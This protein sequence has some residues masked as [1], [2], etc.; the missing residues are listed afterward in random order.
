MRY[1]INKQ[2]YHTFETFEV[3]KLPARSYFIPFSDKIKADA[4]TILNKRYRS[5]KVRCLNGNWDFCFFSRPAE[6]PDVLDTDAIAFDTIDVPSC[7]QFRGYDKPFYVNKR[8]QF[9][10]NPPVIPK[11]EPVGKTFYVESG[12]FGSK[13]AWATPVEEYNFVGVYRRKFSVDDTKKNRVITFLG[14]A[15]CLDLYV[16]GQFVGYSEGSHNTAEF[17]LT[18]YLHAGENEL[19]AVVHRWCTGTYLECQDMLRNNGIFRDV[20]LYEMDSAD[21]WDVDFRTEWAEQGYSAFAVAELNADAEVKVTLSGHGLHYEQVVQTANKIARVCFKNLDVQQWNAETPVLYDLYF[22]LENTCVKMRV[23][24]RDVKICG[25]VF[26]LNGSRVKLKGVNHHDTH[27]RNGYTMT[28]EEIRYDVQLCKDYNMDTI[29]TSHYPPD[30]MLLEWCDELGV[31]VVDEGD[32]ETHGVYW[33]QIPRTYNSIT[34]DSRWGPQYMDRVKRLYGRDKAKTC[35]I[36]WSLGNE[37]GGYNNTDKM[38]AWLKEQSALPVHYEGATRSDRVAYDV[39][40]EMYPSFEK[41]HQVANHCRDKWQFNDRPYFICEYAHAMGVGPGSMEDYWK[42]IYAS[43]NLMGGCIWEMID[44][45]VLQPDGSYTYGGDHGEWIHDK[46]FCVD[47][48]F[49]PDRTASTGAKIAAFV[50]RP[51]RVSYAGGSSYEIFN[52][53]AF[54]NA[55]RYRLDF[56]YP[57]GKVVSKKVDLA[58]LSKA[59]YT[60]PDCPATSSA[61]KVVTVDTLTGKDVAVEQLV[62]EIPVRKD[63]KL[64]GKLPAWIAEQDGH[65]YFDKAGKRMAPSDRHTILFRAPTDNDR[66]FA[67]TSLMDDFLVQAEFVR[68]KSVSEQ[69]IS[70]K[71]EI[72][73]RKH[74]FLCTDTYEGCEEGVLVTSHLKCVKG[75]AENLPRFGKAYAL[76]QAFDYVTYTARNGETYCD[77]KDQAQIETVSC[78]VQEMTEPNIKPQESGNRCD[79]TVTTVSDGDSAYTFT[80][81]D[82]PYELGIK[83]YTDWELIS[84]KHRSDEIRTGTYVTVSAFQMGIG[85]ASCGP[86]PLPEYCYSTNE[87][88]TLRYI[89]G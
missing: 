73:C 7:W 64:T 19:L 22:E 65:I 55:N 61:L 78:R 42:D 27:C 49:Y 37:A 67:P 6:L 18:D 28:P 1:Q 26:L 33:Q 3:N 25:D 48:I 17:D 57:D 80:A 56:I 70:I 68:E 53:T 5:D 79:C 32:L 66:S 88:Y 35:V 2:N 9:P 71:T 86:R 4:V 63:V 47:G 40:S 77:M 76:D 58:P 11:E 8:Y 23:G 85:S 29:R 39:G 44:H 30:P 12:D 43:D 59:V 54:S 82:R 21:I 69:R 13:P 83:P 62:F 72:V 14:V 15:S 41:V 10:Y 38:Y 46:H 60:F 75:E 16:N 34:H 20:L 51:I 24:F 52:T 31:Y 36:M 81:V 87:A 89:I 45:A 84:M 74:T 50:Y